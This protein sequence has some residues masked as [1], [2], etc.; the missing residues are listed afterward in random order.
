MSIYVS[1]CV[2]RYGPIYRIPKGSKSSEHAA[3][4]VEYG[5]DEK[6][7]VSVKKRHFV[8]NRYFLSA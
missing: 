8:S 4:V 5:H 1:G 6:F 7:V 3:G 2:Y